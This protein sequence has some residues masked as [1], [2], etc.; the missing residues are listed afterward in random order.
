MGDMDGGKSKSHLREVTQFFYY[1][2]IPILL[3]EMFSLPDKK[4][5][6]RI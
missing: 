6:T 2:Y 4:E 3:I 1:S 5:F